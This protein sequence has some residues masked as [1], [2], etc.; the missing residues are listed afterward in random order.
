MFKTDDKVVQICLAISYTI[1]AMYAF[2]NFFNPAYIIDQYPSLES[3]DTTIFFLIWYG[4]MNFGAVAGIIYMGYKGL[5]RAYFAYAIP[6]SLLFVWWG[7]SGQA[8]LE[9][10]EQRWAA[11]ILFA[12]NF[13]ALVIAR[14]KG[15]G[16]F[17]IDK[18]DSAWGTDD[19]IV[20]V[21]L[22]LAIIGQVVFIIQYF[23]NPA[24]FIEQTPGLEMSDTAQ[25]FADGLMYFA[26][27][28]TIT[29]LYQFRCG[30]SMTMIVTGLVISVMFFAM[31]LN[32]QASGVVEDGGNA[33]LTAVVIG[34][35]VG[36][37]I[38]FFRLQSQ[39]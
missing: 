29:L 19:K 24:G 28:W 13:L 10:D 4:M 8:S 3:N 14:V 34:N 39:H 22:Y 23:V 2:I 5:D 12:V 35:F 33:Q 25:R 30:Y 18:A 36:S 15:M 9:A 6:L 17:N 21:V 1:L 16:A 31:M 38:L 20:Q 27:A 11:T 32:F 26:V 37:L 7:Y